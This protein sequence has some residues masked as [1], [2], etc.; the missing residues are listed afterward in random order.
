MSISRN[1]KLFA[2]CRTIF[3]FADG[4]CRQIADDVSIR[5]FQLLV[6]NL[7]GVRARNDPLAVFLDDQVGFGE[8]AVT[9]FVLLYVDADGVAGVAELFDGGDGAVDVLAGDVFVAETPFVFEI[10]VAHFLRHRDNNGA[11]ARLVREL[12][13]VCFCGVQ[14]ETSASST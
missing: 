5:T 4:S 14:G 13:T 1:R 2:L 12:C 9:G 11:V 6:R 7:V 3:L 10:P 8:I